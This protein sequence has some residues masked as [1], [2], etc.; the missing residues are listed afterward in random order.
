MHISILAVLALSSSIYAAP[1]PAS[2][3]ARGP[4]QCGQYSS[5]ST[6]GFTV[7]SNEWGASTSGTTGSQCSYIDSLTGSSLAWHTT[8]TWAGTS[9]QVK[10]YTNAEVSLAQKAVSAYTTIPTTW[11]WSYTGTNLACNGTYTSHPL[12]QTHH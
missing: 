9:T 6:G 1:T 8:W 2:L 12:M 3:E 5:I 10:S 7:Y 11:K 4:S